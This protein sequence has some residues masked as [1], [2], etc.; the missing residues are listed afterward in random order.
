[1]ASYRIISADSHMMEPADLWV[2][3]IDKAFRDRA[4]RVVVNYEG[5]PGAFFV[6]EGVD[7]RPVAGFAAAGKSAEELVDF[8][9]V[10]YEGIRPGGWDPVERIK[11]QDI[12]GVDAEILYTSLGMPLFGIRDMALQQACFR[13]YNDWLAE[14][15][16]YDPSRFVGLGLIC[17]LDVDAG[18]KEL[19]RCARLGLKGAMIWASPPEDHVYGDPVYD[20]FWAAAQDLNMPLSLHILTGRSRESRFDP[21]ASRI[22]RYMTLHHEVQRALSDLISRGV[23]ERF[24]GLKIVSSENDIGWIAHFLG[25]LDHAYD[26][27]RHLDGAELQMQ[28]SDYFRRQVWATFQ[29]DR[30]GVATRDFVGTDRL[31]W[32]SD[33]PHTDATWPESQQVI[34]KDFVE[35]PAAE[36][37]RMICDNAAELYGL[38]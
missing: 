18:V 25:R 2:K 1:M 36:K 37:Q 20:P 6:A 3:R 35:V 38:V 4:P 15:V 23:L 10:G 7:P 34:E 14:F 12:D 29:D 26:K 19:Q 21:R 32:A 24:P 31:M 13:A 22:N 16:A 5:K 17:L 9:S 33:Y 28:P 30:V 11:D 8:Q 27:F